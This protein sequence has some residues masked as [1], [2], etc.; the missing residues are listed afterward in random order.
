M[1]DMPSP[2]GVIAPVRLIPT[3]TSSA[4]IRSANRRQPSASR[5]AL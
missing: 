2:A 5:P 1:V 3:V 4:S